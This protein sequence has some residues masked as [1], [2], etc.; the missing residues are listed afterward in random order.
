MLFGA[1]GEIVAPGGNFA[2]AGVDGV[3]AAAYGADGRHQRLLHLVQASRQLTHLIAAREGD[4]LR[5]IASRNGANMV[6]D[7]VERF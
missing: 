2:C 6:H 3:G 4:I 5:Q 1:G 7:G